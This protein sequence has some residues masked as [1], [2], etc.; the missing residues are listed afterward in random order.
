MTNERYPHRL[1]AMASLMGSD[2]FRPPVPGDC[3]L[4]LDGFGFVETDHEG[5]TMRYEVEAE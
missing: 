1:Y 5:K 3:F 2:V 4:R